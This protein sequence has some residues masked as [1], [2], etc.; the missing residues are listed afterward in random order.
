MPQPGGVKKLGLARGATWR[1]GREEPPGARGERSHLARGATLSEASGRSARP[2][3][4]K[5]ANTLIGKRE[6]R[7]F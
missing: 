1:E 5:R 4:S 2:L 6:G 7:V 3:R